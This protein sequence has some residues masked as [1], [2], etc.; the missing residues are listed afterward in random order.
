MS[1]CCVYRPF[2]KIWPKNI[3]FYRYS[4][5]VGQ[6]AIQRAVQRAVQPVLAHPFE[7]F[8]TKK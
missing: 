2:T 5:N 3:D 6:R 1:I 8:H 4:Y 7:A